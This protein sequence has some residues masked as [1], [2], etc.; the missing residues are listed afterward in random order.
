MIISPKIEEPDTS[1][2]DITKLET[3]TSQARQKNVD[4]KEEDELVDQIRRVGGLNHAIV[5][6]AK[7]D[8][9][10]EIICGQRRW[11]AYIIL[12]TENAEKYQTI[13]AKVIR[14]DPKLTEEEKKVISF[15]E[16]YGRKKMEKSDYSDVIEYFYKNVNINIE[17]DTFRNHYYLLNLGRQTRLL[18]R[19]VKLS[20]A[21]EDGSIIEYDCIECGLREY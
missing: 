8:G 11:G 12:V 15:V 5:V 1:V 3:G 17:F 2:I 14:R 4:V 6:E 16:N 20:F 18:G 13:R 21:V 9:G 7:D 19:W 10:F